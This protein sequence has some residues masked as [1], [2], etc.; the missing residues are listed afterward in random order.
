[1]SLMGK[2]AGLPETVSTHDVSREAQLE[3]ASTRQSM[4]I[5]SK[6]LLGFTVPVILILCLL[7]RPTI[8]PDKHLVVAWVRHD[9]RA[10]FNRFPEVCFMDFTANTTTEKRPLYLLCFK[11]SSGYCPCWFYCY[12]FMTF[13]SKK[14]LT[15][16]HLC[17]RGGGSCTARV[18]SE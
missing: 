11:T 5:V 15:S 18:R 13:V 10:L 17:I 4:Q 14:L 2:L 6:M 1:M 3:I 7:I 12:L 9:E 16:V 8:A